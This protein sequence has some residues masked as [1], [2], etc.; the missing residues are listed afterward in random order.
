MK[1]RDRAPRGARRRASPNG[2]ARTAS[3]QSAPGKAPPAAHR[4]GPDDPISRATKPS[5]AKHEVVSA[6]AAMD[7]EILIPIWGEYYV[8]RF[9][10][11]G[12]RSLLAPH[13]L[14]WLCQHHS[15]KVTVLTTQPGRDQ[16][17]RWPS[18]VELGRIAEVSYVEI[19]DLVLTYGPNY[20]VILTRAYNR[21]MALSTDLVGRNF[22]YLVADQVFADGAL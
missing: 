10:Q 17:V 3:T 19:D 2:P 6:A 16:C 4:G 1:P 14:P 13:N 12:L 9:A 11:F 21:A 15:V 7:L 22:I 20:S 5:S 18:F 8:R